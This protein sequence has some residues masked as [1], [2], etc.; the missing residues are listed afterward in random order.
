MKDIFSNYHKQKVLSH[1]GILA[2]SWV[3]AISVNMFMLGWTTGDSLK[4]NIRELWSQEL[5]NEDIRISHDTD[6][7]GIQNTQ[8][9]DWVE[10]ISLSFAYDWEL[11][12]LWET[13]SNISGVDIS[14]I[15][16]TPWF[17]S[18][19]L[20]FDAPIDVSENSEILKISYSKKE[21][22]T[23]YLNP[24]NINFIDASDTT[25]S[26]TASSLIF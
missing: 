10:Q 6:T 5:V 9:M 7:I 14:K 23:I 18:F 2:I 15:E 11:L 4:A 17:S 1:L 13:S 26:L 25:Y 8:V 12:E 24:I 21:D 22:E 3:L 19:M 16:T 20:V